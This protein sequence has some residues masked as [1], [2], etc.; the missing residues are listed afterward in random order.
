MN[1]L[2]TKNGKNVGKALTVVC[3]IFIIINAFSIF[4]NFLNLFDLEAANQIY[5][6]NNID[7]VLTYPMVIYQIIMSILIVVAAVFTLKGEKIGIF[8]YLGVQIIGIIYT[9]ITKTFIFDS[10]YSLVVM[11]SLLGWLIYRKKD[12]FFEPKVKA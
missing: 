1:L 2:K 10:L 7:F 12:I 11:I 4:G 6:D 8:I 9:I 3:A 5:V